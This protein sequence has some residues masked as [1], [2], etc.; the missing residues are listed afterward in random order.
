MNNDK[1]NLLNYDFIQLQ[2]CVNDTNIN[3]NISHDG[4]FSIINDS[5]IENYEELKNMLINVNY[6]I[7]SETNSE[8][9]VNL[10]SYYYKITNKTSSS[11]IETIKKLKGSYSICIINKNENNKFYCITNKKKLLLGINDNF[12]IISSQKNNFNNIVY[13]YIILNNNDLCIIENMKIISTHKYIYI[14][15]IFN[16]LL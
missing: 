4:I 14:N 9:I 13:K 11:I 8:I 15:P 2:S 10:I 3:Y 7:Y 12:I 6:K 16:F 5:I 1:L